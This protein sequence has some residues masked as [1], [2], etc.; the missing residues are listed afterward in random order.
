VTFASSAAVLFCFF[1]IFEQ[2]PLVER[3]AWKFLFFHTVDEI[4]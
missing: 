4:D 3:D 1:G 2:G